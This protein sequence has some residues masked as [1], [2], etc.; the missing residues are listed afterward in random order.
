M[1]QVVVI[2]TCTKCGDGHPATTEFFD[3]DSRRPL[4]LK[5]WCKKCCRLATRAYQSNNRD[6]VNAINRQSNN[7]YR[8]ERA[9]HAREY[10]SNNH[11]RILERVSSDYRSHPE[12]NLYQAA[13]K[14]AKQKGLEFNLDLGDIRIPTVCPYLGVRLQV[15]SG[16]G[17][18]PNSPT[19]DRID[20][21]K[22]YIKGNVEVISWRANRLK[23]DGTLKELW[24]IAERLEHLTNKELA[25]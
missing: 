9:A 19:L 7:K 4:G 24:A 14:R 25:A 12:V 2:K 21:T 13:L 17:M 23:S 11:V 16:H 20:P 6:K 18:N 10:Y 5:P 3:R 15:N 22:G 1:E 8:Q